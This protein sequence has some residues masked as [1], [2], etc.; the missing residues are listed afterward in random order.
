MHIHLDPVGGVA[1]DMFV[2][3]MLDCWPDLQSDVIAGVRAAGL[4]ERVGLALQPFNDG[5]LAG[6]RFLVE[7]T[8]SSLATED[9]HHHGSTHQPSTDSHHHHHKHSHMHWAELRQSLQESKLS[10]SVKVHVIGIFTELA[11]AEAK[12]HGKDIGSVAFHEVGHWD[13]IADIVA[14]SVLIEATGVDSWSV[15]AI[16]LGSGRIETAH[17][18]LAV[19]APATSLLLEGFACVDDGR[20][21]ER[22][23][24]T[25]AAILR[26]LA[27]QSSIGQ[28]PRRLQHSGF[29]FGTKR[30]SGISNVLR[31]LVFDEIDSDTGT[32]D[33]VG[34]L[35]FDIDDQSGEEL[36]V[37]L[38]HL[39]DH[40]SV[41]DV[42]QSMALGKKN[43]MVSQIQVL[44]HPGSI[45]DCC[46]VCFAQTTTLGIRTRIEQRTILRRAHVTTVDGHRVKV[47]QR[48]GGITA[49][50][51]MD[52]VSA[53]AAS[54]RARTEARAVAERMALSDRG[55]FGPAGQKVSDPKGD[56]LSTNPAST[57]GAS[58]GNPD[59]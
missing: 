56:R 50:T 37:A 58:T 55:S 57:S 34:V 49:K 33:Y 18:E 15:G 22:V 20:A 36:A 54:H 1:G 7:L 28:S 43:R 13:S 51:E 41:I 21:G 14:A 32:S 38:D 11:K 9:L 17:G 48:P 45:A 12:V 47:V 39:R 6:S 5:V 53:D 52:D 10:D 29:G 27:P 8:D 26:Y 31:L 2:A 16:P 25:G 40:V 46:E 19:P 35:E 42:T 30:L 59:D 4:G 23:T 3:A 24:P 44:V